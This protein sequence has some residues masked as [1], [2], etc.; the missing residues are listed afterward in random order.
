M[1]E[2]YPSSHEAEEDEALLRKRA[3]MLARRMVD[4]IRAVQEGAARIGGGSC[5]RR[6]PSPG[7]RSPPGHRRGRAFR[8]G[9]ACW[10]AHAGAAAPARSNAAAE[11]QARTKRSS[12][13][14]RPATDSSASGSSAPP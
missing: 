11:C 12:H 4:P 6:A 5:R 10:R 2:S 7:R 3:K 1:T 14:I 9:R 13:P 8:G